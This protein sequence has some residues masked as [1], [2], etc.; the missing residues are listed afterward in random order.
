VQHS[1]Y[2]DFRLIRFHPYPG[3]TTQAD[4]LFS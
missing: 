3:H 1:K 4:R 2:L